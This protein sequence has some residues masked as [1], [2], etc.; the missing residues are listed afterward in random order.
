MIW[1]QM[2]R[3]ITNLG[4]DFRATFL[5]EKGEESINYSLE[6]YIKIILPGV[7]RG[8]KENI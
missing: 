3:P 7:L 8:Y 2:E 1:E 4:M 5:E 6:G